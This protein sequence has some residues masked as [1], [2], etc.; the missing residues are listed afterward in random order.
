[1]PLIPPDLAF[2]SVI[3]VFVSG[4]ATTIILV[5]RALTT[6]KIVVGR[7]YEDSLRREQTWQNAHEVA[8]RTNAELSSYLGRLTTIME[9]TAATTL[10]TL[11]LVRARGGVSP[12]DHD[13]PAA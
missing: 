12:P 1:M 8:M 4:L 10:E 11:A 5:L 2:W 7:H 3:V 6:G 9:Q 13:R